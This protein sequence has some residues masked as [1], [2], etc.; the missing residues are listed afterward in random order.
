MAT[1]NHL[2]AYMKFT[3][4]IPSY[5]Q[6]RFIE[7]T[8]KSILKQHG[9]AQQIIVSD[10]GST[11]DTVSILKKYGDRI[12][13]W[14]APD[15]GFADAVNKALPF[16]EGDVV[17]IQS[18]DDYYLPGAFNCVAEV[19]RR[20][21]DV[22]FVAAG[23]ISID[24]EYKVKN[25]WVRR[26]GVTPKNLFPEGLRQHATFIRVDAFRSLGGVRP[27]VDMCSDADLW[28]RASHYYKG[29][30]IPKILGVY[31]LHSDQR[32]Q[33]S[34][35]WL[36][37]LKGMVE[38][39]ENDPVLGKIFRFT[40][41][42]K[43]DLYDQWEFEWMRPPDPAALIQLAQQ[44]VPRM[45][46]SRSLA[47]KS[48]VAWHASRPMGSKAS[49]AAFFLAHGLGVAILRFMIMNRCGPWIRKYLARG[50]DLRWTEVLIEQY[51]D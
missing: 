31:Q 22:Q 26:G 44:L 6:G 50:V 11:D 43:R 16:I 34:A 8:I 29:V 14:S 21:K 9:P 39:A 2:G 37:S 3:I 20:D 7:R 13:W 18:S 19:L 24:S 49:K 32:T 10:G 23:D 35:K 33:T 1:T 30:K 36:N 48:L 17:G 12:T 51:R 47:L 45:R 38:D 5:N 46:Y 42:Q 40:E 41:T 4:V 25:V 27:Q 28:F 15:K